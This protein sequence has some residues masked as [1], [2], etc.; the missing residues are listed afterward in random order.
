MFAAAASDP[1]VRGPNISQ[2]FSEAET[3]R[4]PSG[5]EG[6]GRGGSGRGRVVYHRPSQPGTITTAGCSS[7]VHMVIQTKFNRAQAVPAWCHP[8]WQGCITQSPS[9]QCSQWCLQP[10][11]N[12]EAWWGREGAGAVRHGRRRDRRWQRG[13][14]GSG[15]AGAGQ[16]GRLWRPDVR[17]C[18]GRSAHRSGRRRRGSPCGRGDSGACSALGCSLHSSPGHPSTCRRRDTVVFAPSLQ[19]DESTCILTGRIWLFHFQCQR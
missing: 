5:G 18:T 10:N 8:P 9:L 11:D 3:G 14:S 4:L 16:P 13:R 17:G 7:C 12:T 15:G 19:G 6:S 1:A 2:P